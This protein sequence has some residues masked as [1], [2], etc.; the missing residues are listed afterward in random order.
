METVFLYLILLAGF[1]FFFDGVIRKLSEGTLD[2][3]VCV[4][5]KDVEEHQSQDTWT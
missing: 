5:D 4:I 1:S 3:T 2:P